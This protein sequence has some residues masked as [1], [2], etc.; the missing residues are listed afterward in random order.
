MQD[1]DFNGKTLICDM[2]GTLLNSKSQISEKN[3][4]A[5]WD[6][7]QRGGRFTIGDGA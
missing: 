3:K 5:L 6:F 1:K 4:K 2:D 7:V